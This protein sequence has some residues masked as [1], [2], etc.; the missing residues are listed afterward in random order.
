MASAVAWA[1]NLGLDIDGAALE[2]AAF[3]V[4][5]GAVTMVLN[6]LQAKV[7]WLGSLLS[8]GLS[9]NTPAY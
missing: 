4:S 7:P 8:L 2:A 5:V 9:K 6:W 3:S 1:A